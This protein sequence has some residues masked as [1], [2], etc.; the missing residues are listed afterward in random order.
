MARKLGE[1]GV[2]PQVCA[3]VFDFHNDS[4]QREKEAKRQTLLEIVE[5]PT[6]Q[7]KAPVVVVV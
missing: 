2:A 5:C 1:A 3:V 4:N 7:C 6:R